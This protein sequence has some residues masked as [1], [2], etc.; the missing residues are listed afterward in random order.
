MEQRRTAGSITCAA[1]KPH[2][3][4]NGASPDAP[5]LRWRSEVSLRCTQ[6]ILVDRPIDR[7]P[8]GPRC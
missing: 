3:S 2:R 4:C 7:D 1:M 8:G 5:V 6:A